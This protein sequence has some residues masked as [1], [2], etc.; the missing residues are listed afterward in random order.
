MMALKR[1]LG[2]G[3]S[4]LLAVDCHDKSNL[5]RSLACCHSVR[6]A[7]ESYQ[8]TK[9]VARTSSQRNSETI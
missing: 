9:V 7:V 2:G 4:T 3:D 6:A 1:K 5:Q 8:W